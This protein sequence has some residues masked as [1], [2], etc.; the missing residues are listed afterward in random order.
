MTREEEDEKEFFE[1]LKTHPR[2][3]EMA[4]DIGKFVIGKEFWFPS[5]RKLREKEG[6]N[7]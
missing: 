1:F 4:T 5:R 6:K 7:G 2:Q 3:N